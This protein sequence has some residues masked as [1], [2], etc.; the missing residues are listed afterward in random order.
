MYILFDRFWGPKKR[1]GSGRGSKRQHGPYWNASAAL[2]QTGVISEAYCEGSERAF[3]KSEP[4]CSGKVVFGKNTPVA[5]G[6]PLT[7]QEDA[8]SAAEAWRAKTEQGYAQ[9][10]SK[11]RSVFLSFFVSL[12]GPILVSS[13]GTRVALQRVHFFCRF[14]EPLREGIQMARSGFTLEKC[15]FP[16]HRGKLL[17]PFQGPFWDPKNVIKIMICL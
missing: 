3:S 16:F 9:E 15:V 14:G 1:S 12:S 2:Q 4:G 6:V 10:G 17:R 11:T 5:A 13:G 8:R 7:R